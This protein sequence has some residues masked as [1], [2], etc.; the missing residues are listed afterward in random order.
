[1]SFTTPAGRQ[2]SAY[3]VVHASRDFQALKRQFSGFVVPAIAFFLGWYFLYVLCAG[4]APGFMRARLFGEVNVGLCFGLLQFA[5]TFAIAIG[6]LRWS[7]RKFD[8]PAARLRAQLE[9]GNG[10]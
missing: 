7:K 8:A 5:S 10:Q 1:M 6:H 9:G 3:E 4:F 2:V